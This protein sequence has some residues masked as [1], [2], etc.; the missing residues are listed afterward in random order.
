MNSK[1]KTNWWIDLVLF[2]GFTTTFF[3]NLTGV[4][5][6]QWIGILSGAL[7]V[8]HLL[9]HLNWV[10]AVSKRFFSKTSGQARIY[11]AL[12][13]LLL[14]GFILIGITGLVI[15]TWLNFSLSNF[16]LWLK[17][18]ITISIVTLTIL[19]LKLGFHSHWIVRTTRKI[20]IKP[21]IVPARNVIQPSKVNSNRTGRREFLQVM[22]IVG[23]GAFLAL[24]N[25]SKS[26]TDAAAAQT[27]SDTET[28]VLQSSSLSSS[29]NCT[30]SCRRACSY[31][32][33]CHKYTDTNNNGRCDL[34]EC[35]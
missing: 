15:S 23:A 13:V 19:L 14:L 10:E 8:Y 1:Q 3:L 27:T 9:L 12:D 16:T 17:T 2:I 6:H 34:G 7:A 4:E 24:V 32:G 22:G 35:I 5:L 18:H 11:Y 33:H 31:P 29:S 28:T 30:V 25:A 26:L 21:V 20:L